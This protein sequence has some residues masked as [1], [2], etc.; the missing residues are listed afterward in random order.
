[1]RP[2]SPTALANETWYMFGDTRG[3]MWEEV[4]RARPHFAR[5]HP[6][7]LQLLAELPPAPMNAELENPAAT[8]GLGGMLSGV[9]FHT[10]GAV[11]AEVCA[12]ATAVCARVSVRA[13][14]PRGENV[15]SVSAIRS[16][17]IPGRRHPDAGHAPRGTALLRIHCI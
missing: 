4:S 5:H 8:F 17:R 11:F 6:F 3:G 9:S 15:V 2:Q 1:M 13:G 14:H 12:R 7:L 10:H 16:S